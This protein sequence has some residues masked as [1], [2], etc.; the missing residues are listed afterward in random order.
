MSKSTHWRGRKPCGLGHSSGSGLSDLRSVSDRLPFGANYV[1]DRVTFSA[2]IRLVALAEPMRMR[3][4]SNGPGG[5][6]VRKVRV[7][8]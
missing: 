6:G 7:L 1:R 5:L 4:A 8:M 2:D 3:L